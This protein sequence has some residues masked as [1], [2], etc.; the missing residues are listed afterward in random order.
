MPQPPQLLL[1]VDGSLMHCPEH[2]SPG[3]VVVQVPLAQ[4][5][6]DGQACPQL[7]QCWA[8]LPRSTQPTLGQ[9]VCP[10]VAQ[11]QCPPMQWA[12][13]SHRVPHAPQL[14]SFP[15]GSMQCPEHLISRLGQ[16]QVPPLHCWSKS[17]FIPQ[18]PQFS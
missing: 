10:D 13:T 18:L 7:P 11:V 9:S 3:H 14:V 1:S 15:M 16:V 4:P 17:H 5:S 6:P 12:P 2:M 8:L